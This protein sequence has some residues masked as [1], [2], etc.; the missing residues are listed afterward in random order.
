MKRYFTHQNI[1]F[2]GL[3]LLVVGIPLSR[4]LVSVSQFVLLANWL[5]ERNFI[6]KWHSI[7]RSKN[8][9]LFVSIYLFY[10]IGLLW[11]SDFAY[12][13]KEIRVKLPML[14]LP[15]LFFTSPPL[16]KREYHAVMHFFCGAVIIASV[17]SL[18]AY[19][20]IFHKKV[21]HVRDISLF[22]SHIRFAL[23][24]V[25]SIIYL[26]YSVI[27]PLF[28]ISRFIYLLLTLWL[29]GFLIFLQS[30]TGLLI[31]GI[32]AFVRICIFLFSKRSALL[33]LSFLIGFA[34]TVT[35]AAYIIHDEYGK[36]YVSKPF[37]VNT[38]P[39]LTANGIPYINDTSI[40]TTENGNLVYVLFCD[41]ELG[42]SW[43]KRSALEYTGKD[44]HG[45]DIRYTILR[46][47]TSKGLAKDS[48]GLAALGDS[49]VKNIENGC[50][51]YL[52]TNKYDI[53][54]RI[55]ETIWE[56]DEAK[57]QQEPN[58][59]SLTMRLEFW[60]TAWHIIKQQPLFGVGTGDVE[61]C[62]AAQYEADKTVLHRHWRLRAHNQFLETT[63]ALGFTG[64][65]IFIISLLTP[66]FSGKKNSVFFMLFLFIQ[67]LSFLNEDTLETQAGVTFC[68]F[69]TQFFFKNDAYNE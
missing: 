38:A 12:A 68:V 56:I 65:V 35:Y 57:H 9:W 46:Y 64:L 25:L 49:D 55:H 32:I 1:F 24:I 37:D 51:N 31:L 40:P 7:K 39:K 20:G 58:G 8:F 44:K 45:N 15:L 43:P 10:V 61:D 36:F 67:Y 34:G 66:F 11:T 2:F 16:R 21:S 63:V 29:L 23:M 17:C 53:R 33:K 50:S 5:L 3:V 54:T 13:T 47:L 41:Y 6:S 18:C 26:F 48:A 69:F 22:E 60:K 28:K 27:H 42:R 52:Y 59:H 4:F 30:F 62:F 19:F 14:W